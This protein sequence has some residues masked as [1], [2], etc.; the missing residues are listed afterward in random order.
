MQHHLL[1]TNS[2][3]QCWCSK[4]LLSYDFVRHLLFQVSQGHRRQELRDLPRALR[5]R[6][7]HE[8]RPV[9]GLRV[10]T[11]LLLPSRLHRDRMPV[12]VRRVRGKRLP[13]RGN[14]HRRGRKL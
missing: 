4:E 5:W 14:M 2:L 9:P 3:I 8:R 6:A 11:Q 13:E 12:R 10:R 7:L 1:R